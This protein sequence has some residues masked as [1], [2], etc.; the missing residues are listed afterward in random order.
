METLII[1]MTEDNRWGALR[2]QGAIKY[3]CHK[4]SYQPVLN[5]LERQKL[6]LSP[7]RIPD[8]SWAKFLTVHLAITVAPD[9]LT[10]EAS[11][12]KG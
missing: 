8:D 12:T 5:V 7:K 3:I 9:F 10:Q 11:N 1:A 6:H 4:V 2:V